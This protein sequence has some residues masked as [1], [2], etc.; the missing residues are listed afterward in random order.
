MNPWILFAL[1]VVVL[2]LALLLPRHHDHLNPGTPRRPR[3][4]R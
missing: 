1:F 4:R 2:A 3:P